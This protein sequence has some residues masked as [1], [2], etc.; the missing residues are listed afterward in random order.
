M[1]LNW[2]SQSSFASILVQTHAYVH[3]IRTNIAMSIIDLADQ[4]C[5]ISVRSESSTKQIVT[6]GAYGHR[7]KHAHDDDDDDDDELVHT[8]ID[9]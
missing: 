8:T 1:T 5:T 3:M 9:N 4:K 7:I 6:N 2:N